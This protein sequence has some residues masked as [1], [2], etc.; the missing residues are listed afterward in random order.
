MSVFILITEI[1]FQVCSM[2]L[3]FVNNDYYSNNIDHKCRRTLKLQAPAFCL[4]PPLSLSL[5]MTKLFTWTLNSCLTSLTTNVQKGGLFHIYIY[6]SISWFWMELAFVSWRF[7]YHSW[8]DMLKANE[9]R[10]GEIRVNDDCCSCPVSMFVQFN[11]PFQ[12]FEM[13]L[14]IDMRF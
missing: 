1:A 7:E 9:R 4:L 5:S 2:R 8:Y 12:I 3:C 10:G 11:R 14:V 6:P 13:I